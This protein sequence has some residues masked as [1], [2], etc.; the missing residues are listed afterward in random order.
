[1]RRQR[2]KLKQA[3]REVASLTDEVTDLR[4]RGHELEALVGTTVTTTSAS[5]L[6]LGELGR[7]LG[8]LSLGTTGRS[9][10]SAL[11]GAGGGDAVSLGPGVVPPD[12]LA[13]M[14]ALKDRQESYLSAVGVR[15]KA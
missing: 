9:G 2:K 5:A 13:D 7:G 10:D 15:V 8:G 1:M 11:H 6:G 3:R 14:A 4:F 12:V